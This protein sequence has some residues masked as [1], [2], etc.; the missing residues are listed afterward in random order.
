[1]DCPACHVC[2]PRNDFRR[3]IVL[4]EVIWDVDWFVKYADVIMSHYVYIRR[5][6]LVKYVKK[7]LGCDFLWVYSV[8]CIF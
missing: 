4:D 2:I 5:A 8:L 3:C 7:G 1:M 6:F